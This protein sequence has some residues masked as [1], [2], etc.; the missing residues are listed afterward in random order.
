MVGDTNSVVNDYLSKPVVINSGEDYLNDF[1][2]RRGNGEAR[3]I[4]F[5]INN[6]AIFLD[7]ENEIQIIAKIKILKNIDSLFFCLFVKGSESV[8][9]ITSSKLIEICKNNL[10][11]GEIFE[12]EFSI[13]A[14]TFRTGL[15]PLYIWIGRKAELA[16]DNYPY[17]L[18]D[19][20]YNFNFVSDKSKNDLGY[21]PDQ[22]NGYFN[23]NFN[24]INIKAD[25]K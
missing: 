15:Y 21:N 3:F 16:E 13:P 4:N 17:D 6:G 22:P 25:V 8:D 5:S 18:I 14:N 19:S 23:L 7:P 11:V 2:S 20:V 24:K 12:L 10:L 1:T 9:F